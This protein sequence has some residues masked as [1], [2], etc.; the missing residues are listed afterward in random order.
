MQSVSEI[1]NLQGKKVILRLDLNVPLKN[2]EI[3]DTTR[4]DKILPTIEFLLKQ[5]SKIIIL[6]HVGRPKGKVIRNLSLK[7]IQEDI[8][9]KLNEKINLIEKNIYEIK[10]DMFDNFNEKILLIENIRF[11]PDEEKNDTKFA[12]HLASLGDI[13]VN[14]AF[15]CSHRAHTSVCEISK[16]LPSFTLGLAYTTSKLPLFK[17]LNEFACCNAFACLSA[18]IAPN[19]T[20]I[21]VILYDCFCFHSIIFIFFYLFPH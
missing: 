2:G 17:A 5:N 7:P 3:T 18:S 16:F 13:Y 20:T 4:I 8:E 21:L 19:S 11:Y 6:S 9:K 12:K 15:S 1:T 10:K 14:D